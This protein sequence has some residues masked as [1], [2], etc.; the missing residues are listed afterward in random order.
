MR[1]LFLLFFLLPVMALAQNK[2]ITLE[3]IYKKGTFRGEFVPAVFDTTKKEPELKLDGLKD[4]NGKPFGQPEEE[5]SNPVK[6]NLY[7]LKKRE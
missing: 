3:D 2:P 6:T 1:K 7:L 5:I 4:E